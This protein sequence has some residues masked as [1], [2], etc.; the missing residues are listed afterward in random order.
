MVAASLRQ[1]TSVLS[2]AQACVNSVVYQCNVINA[3]FDGTLNEIHHMVLAA[4]KANNEI[5]TYGEM[6][7]QDDSSEFVKAMVSEIGAREARGH[8]EVVRRNAV[9]DGVKTI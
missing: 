4:G 6:L 1:P 5:Y 3:N 2:H 8:W 9:L 7:K